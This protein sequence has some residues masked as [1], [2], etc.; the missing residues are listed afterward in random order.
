MITAPCESK[1]PFV[2]AGEDTFYS[3][4]TQKSSVLLVNA[5]SS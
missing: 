5:T 2:S 1:V 3:S 4:M